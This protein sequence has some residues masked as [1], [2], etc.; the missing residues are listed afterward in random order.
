MNTG[1]VINSDEFKKCVDFH[2]HLCPGLSIGYKASKAAMAWLE[3]NRAADEEIVAIVETDACSADA[4]QVVTGCTFGKGNFIFKDYGKMALTLFSRK[5]GRGV[6]VVRRPGDLSQNKPDSD[7][8]QKIRNGEAGENEKSRFN[9]LRLKQC[10]DMLEMPDNELFVID[11]V[12][13][14]PPP[15]ARVEASEL[16]DKCKEP[17]MKTKLSLVDGKKMCRGCIEQSPC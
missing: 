15:A 3:E 13:I 5:T 14:K 4:I 1:Q 7:L 9:E 6:R 16:C 11:P 12:Q 10:R 2:G 8:F 17:T